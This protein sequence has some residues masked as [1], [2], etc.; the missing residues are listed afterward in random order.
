MTPPGS[1][2]LAE[3]LGRREERR[4]E[5][6]RREMEKVVH[7]LYVGTRTENVTDIIEERCC[8]VDI[9]VSQ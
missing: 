6:E 3:N 5:C 1:R 8:W 4:Q 2:V 9:G 7:V